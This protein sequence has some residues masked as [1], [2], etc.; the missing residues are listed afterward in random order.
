M[1]NIETGTSM[2]VPR[3]GDTYI[4]YPSVHF[5]YPISYWKK[6]MRYISFFQQPMIMSANVQV[7]CGAMSMR[8]QVSK[9]ISPWQSTYVHSLYLNPGVVSTASVYIISF[10]KLFSTYQNENIKS[11]LWKEIDAVD[12]AYPETSGGFDNSIYLLPG[13][14]FSIFVLTCTE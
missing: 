5:D 1:S 3:K 2:Y 7:L 10:I 9:K 13:E 4:C 12:L 11:F 8:E 6:Q 14:V